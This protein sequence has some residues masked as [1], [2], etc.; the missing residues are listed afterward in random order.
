[1]M[2]KH[3]REAER[4]LDKRC[5]VSFDLAGP[6]LRT[7]P[8]VPGPAV[9]KWR[10]TRNALGQVTE[11]ARVRLVA[12]SNQPEAKEPTIP[13]EAALLGKARPG[14]TFAFAVACNRKRVLHVSQVHPGECLCETERTAYVVPGTCLTLRREQSSIVKGN[15]GAL[16][17]IEQGIT[18]RAGDTL[19]VVH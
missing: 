8:I 13:V 11:L 4:S 19:E 9:A 5:L 12:G 7:G 2:V 10:P 1:M 17:T 18:L 6:K 16:P 3:L 15:V 14:D